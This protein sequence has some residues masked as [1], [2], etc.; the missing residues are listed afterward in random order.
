MRKTL[1]NISAIGSLVLMAGALAAQTQPAATSAK[2]PAASSTKPVAKHAKPVVKP[3]AKGKPAKPT[4]AAKAP[5]KTPAPA[6][7]VTRKAAP[8][9]AQPRMMAKNVTEPAAAKKTGNNDSSVVKGG[10]RDPFLNPI[11][12][13]Q[14]KASSSALCTT[15]GSQCLMIDQLT[16]LGVVK[17]QKGMIAMVEN[18][19]KKQVNLHENDPVMNGKVIRITRDSI[20]FRESALDNFGRPTTR[21]VVKKVTVP[22]V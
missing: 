2:K 4:V 15:S 17:T 10:R 8:V 21:E 22:V 7:K 13:Q 20:V 6:K 1:F 16:L 19:T 9:A 11:K 5:A 14:D 3:I 18:A 12:L